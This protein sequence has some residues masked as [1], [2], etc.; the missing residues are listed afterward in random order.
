VA[1]E[2]TI[3][4]DGDGDE[5]APVC[6]CIHCGLDY[7]FD[8]PQ[9]LVR[10]A[11]GRKVLIFAGAGISTEVPTVF[12]QTIYQRAV[13]ML[14]LDEPGSFPD[15]IEA[16][17][18]KHGRRQFVQLV[19]VKFDFIDS[20]WGLRYELATMP[21]WTD[22][23]TT[24]WDTFFEEECAAMPFV[25]GDDIALWDMPGRRVLKIHGSMTNLGSIVATEQDYKQS[26][27][28]LR[29][30]VLGGLLTQ[31]LATVRSS[32]SATPCGTGTFAAC[33]PHFVKIWVRTPKKP[34]LYHRLALT[35][36]TK[37]SS[38]SSR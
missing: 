32:L 33:T 10:A 3:A 26:L 37:S 12:P 15:V 29:K 16:F 14:G 28:N 35:R 5:H 22:I 27:K 8:L 30:G 34:T 4:K 9:E 17:V 19:K 23:V 6:Q 18:K 20:F 24:N 2:I 7:D 21:Y 1:D 31:L 36:T 25:T 13:E 38:T 11:H